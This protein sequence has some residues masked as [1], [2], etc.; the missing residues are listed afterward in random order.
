MAPESDDPQRPSVIRIA[1][2][3]LLVAALACLLWAIWPGAE[4]A[5]EVSIGAPP[6]VR[7]RSPKSRPTPRPSPKPPPASTIPTVTVPMTLRSAPLPGAYC[8]LRQ[9]PALAQATPVRGKCQITR[10]T[11][12]GTSTST[13]TAMGSMIVFQPDGTYERIPNSLLDENELA[14]GLVEGMIPATL[15]CNFEGYVPFTGKLTETTCELPT[16]LERGRLVAGAITNPRRAV[17]VDVCGQSVQADPITGFW[18]AR[19]LD[20]PCE[21]RA[22]V[23][24]DNDEPTCRSAAI[25]VGDGD[26]EDIALTLNQGS[27]DPDPTE[28]EPSPQRP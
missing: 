5:P 23:S 6:A 15:E 2:A 11:F 22:E 9:A 13:S 25:P 3:L 28:P 14:I 4:V 7:P 12:D 17:F 8:D 19:T 24:R 16:Q 27:C 10:T 21:V 26:Q 20:G 1:A 18:E